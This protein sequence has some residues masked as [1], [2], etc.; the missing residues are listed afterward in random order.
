MSLLYDHDLSPGS[1][2]SEIKPKRTSF[3]DDEPS[4]NIQIE[5]PEPNTF[6]EKGDFCN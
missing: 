3:A 2:V 6:F 1:Y 4:L 5:H